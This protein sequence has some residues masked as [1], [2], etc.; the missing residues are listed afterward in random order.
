[1]SGRY[2]LPWKFT[3]S[4][5]YTVQSGVYGGPLTKTLAAADPAF[6]PASITLSNGR[7]VSNPLATTTRLVGP[8]GDNQLQAPLI[9]RLNMRFGKIFKFTDR[10]SIEADADFFNITNNGD[11]LFFLNG[12]NTSLPTFGQYSSTTQSP[13]GVELSLYYRF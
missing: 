3:V 5:I 2:I 8:R 9:K 1:L 6:G 7:V 4:A 10:H 11:P 12:T 13:R